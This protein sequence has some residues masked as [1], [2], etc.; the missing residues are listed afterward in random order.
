VTTLRDVPD[1]PASWPFAPI[2]E[3]DLYLETAHE[4]SLVVLETHTGGH[5]DGSALE[6]ALTAVLAADLSARRHL[7]ATPRWSRRLRWETAVPAIQPDSGVLTMTSWSSPGQLTALREQVSAWPMSL[8]DTAARLLLAVGP[9]HDVVILQT[10]H[11]AFDGISSLALLSAI[12]AAYRDAVG[13]GMGPQAASPPWPGSGPVQ[14]PDPHQSWPGPAPAN[15]RGRNRRGLPLLPGVVTRIAAHPAQPDRPGYGFVHKSVPLP[16][17][18]RQGS[19]PYPTV[20]DLL[21]TALILTVD[22]W[23]AAHGRR[24]GTIRITVPVND[25]DPQRRWEGPGNRSRLIRV[26]AG[27]GRRAGAAGL[28]A[29]VAAQTRA[30]KRQPRPGLDAVSRL[31][32]AGWAP[33]EVKRHT[34]RLARRLARP[35][36]TDTSLVSNLGL[37]SDPPSFSGSGQ[38][39]LWLSGPAPMPRGLAVGA[40][41][42]AGWLHLCVQYRHALLDSRAAADFTAAYCQALAGLA[43]LPQGR[44]P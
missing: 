9:E 15:R 14:P 20:N 11:A 35:V 40:V 26:T 38:E 16:R 21:V 8:N 43:T 12:C 24:S 28:L 4:P 36:C 33:T 37:L 6:A 7:A 29:Q 18:A 1:A 17:P 39:P 13:A 2:E 5:L 22:R 44:P 25:R 23:N 31:L 3:L 34:A 19:G 10:H 32:A 41:T 42:V 27:S 30:A